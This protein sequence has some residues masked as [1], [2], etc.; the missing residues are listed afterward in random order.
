MDQD[1]KPWIWPKKCYSM[2]YRKESSFCFS[3][4]DNDVVVSAAI[5]GRG[6]LVNIRRDGI[7]KIYNGLKCGIRP[8]L[9]V[10]DAIS[11]E[12]KKGLNPYACPELDCYLLLGNEAER[13]LK[14]IKETSGYLEAGLKITPDFSYGSE[15]KAIVKYLDIL[16]GHILYFDSIRA[17]S[18]THLTLPTTPYV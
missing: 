8:N 5:L 12:N 4:V 16:V 9:S 1:I 2:I 18:Y 3:D 15:S 7:T 6:I 13:L 17:V 11:S 14:I 10:I